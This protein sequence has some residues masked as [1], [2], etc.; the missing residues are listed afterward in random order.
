MN[1]V[2]DVNKKLCLMSGEIIAMSP[3][4]NLIFEPMDLAVASPATVSRC[5]MVYMEPHSL[6]WEPLMTSWLATLPPNVTKEQKEHLEE[7][8]MWFLDPCLW[9]L[10]R[11]CRSPVPTTDIMLAV[12]V[13]RLIKSHLDIWIDVPDTPSTAPENKKGVE[14]LQGLFMFSLIWGV[15]A[16]VDESGREKF[17]IFLK[18]LIRKEVPEILTQIPGAS[19]PVIPEKTKLTKAPPDKDTVYNYLFSME[20]GY[21]WIKWTDTVPAYA[22][23]KGAKFNDIFVSTEDTIQ[24][25]YLANVL[26]THQVPML[27][28]GNTGT[29]KTILVR[30][31]MLN[32]M[33]KDVYQNIFLNF[34][35]QTSARVSQGIIDNQLDKRRK[36]VFGPPFG[37]KTASMAFASGLSSTQAQIPP[38]AAATQRPSRTRAAAAASSPSTK[39]AAAR[40]VVTTDSVLKTYMLRSQTLVAGPKEAS[41]TTPAVRPTAATSIMDRIGDDRDT[42]SSGSAMPATSP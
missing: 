13:M 36:G 11:E 30:S 21:A 2:L 4:M 19:Q 16:T 37:R 8:F 7:L 3:V 23:P 41:S 10:R 38:T 28:S 42:S 31:T 32:G 6:G 27:V 18:T 25:G 33:D 34:S 15:G 39:A 35:A 9:Y 12:A 20:K 29:G 40:R 5:G 14:I 22:V 17:D 24:V 26:I 1:T